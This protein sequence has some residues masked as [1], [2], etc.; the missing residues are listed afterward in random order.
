MRFAPRHLADIFAVERAGDVKTSF[1]YHGVWHMPHVIGVE[2]FWQIYRGLDDRSTVRRDLFDILKNVS[3]GIGG[4][5]RAI[6]MITDYIKHG[7]RSAG[8]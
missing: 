2:A 7:L 1:G 6:C 8:S 3:R 4:K 5:R